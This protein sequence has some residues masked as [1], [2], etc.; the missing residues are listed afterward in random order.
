MVSVGPHASALP[1]EALTVVGCGGA[2]LT[3]VVGCGGAALSVVGCG[4][5]ALT[6]VA[7]D[8]DGCGGAELTDGC[9]LT[10]DGG[11]APVVAADGDGCALTTDGGAALTVVALTVAD[12]APGSLGTGGG[13]G[14]PRSLSRAFFSSSSSAVGAPGGGAL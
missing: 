7:V 14:R 3:V 5:A 1:G 6:V 13:S 2:A 10:M 8:D 4:G 11:A 12:P 9:A